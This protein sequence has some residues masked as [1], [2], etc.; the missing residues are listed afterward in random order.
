MEN[1]ILEKYKDRIF[2]LNKEVAKILITT[3]KTLTKRIERGSYKGLYKKDGNN[4]LW[5]KDKFFTEECGLS[6]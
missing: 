6:A 1:L 2:L 5:Y 3:P 4:I